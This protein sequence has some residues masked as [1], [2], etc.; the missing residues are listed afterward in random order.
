MQAGWL[1]EV[2]GFDPRPCARGDHHADAAAAPRSWFRSAPLREGRLRGSCIRIVHPVVSIRAPARG[3]T[4]GGNTLFVTA[5]FRSAPLRE[6]RRTLPCRT[7]L[8]RWFRSAPLREGRRC[9][10]FRPRGADRRMFRSAPLR[11][12]RPPPS[13]AAAAITAFRSAPLREGRRAVDALLIG[14]VI[15]S[16]RAPARGATRKSKRTCSGLAGFDPRPCARGDNRGGKVNDRRGGFDPRPCARGDLGKFRLEHVQRSFDP[17]P[18]ARGDRILA[19]ISC[20]AASF[21]PRPC[22][23]GDASR[24]AFPAR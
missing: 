6:G 21:D 23:R 19:L 3:A 5:T 18:C 12:G 4:G 15:V 17:R 16:I 14:Q 7:G 22:A 20:K 10:R 24:R 1:T 11:E 13:V 8:P 2:R 9:Y